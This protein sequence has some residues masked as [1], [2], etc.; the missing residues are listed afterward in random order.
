MNTSANEIAWLADATVHDLIQRFPLPIAL[1]DDAGG[2]L[3][4]NER[5]GRTY[6]TEALASAPLQDLMRNPV[7][8]WHTVRVPDLGQVE[9]EIKAQVLRVQGN[10]MLILDDATDPGLLREL[11]QLH[12]QITELERLSSTDRLTGAWNRAHLD[13]VVAAELDRSLRSRQPVSLILVDID[14]FKLVN[15]TYGHQTGDSVLCELV[16]VIGGAIRSV[17]TLF[18]WGGEEFVVLASSSGYR[19]GTTVAE[20]LRARVA[21]HDFAGVGKVTISLGVAEHIATESAEIWFQRVDRALYRAKDG[22]RNRVCV[23]EQGSSDIWAAESGSS[24][25]RLVW[26]EAYECGEPAIDREHRELFELANALLDASF[27]SESA[28]EVFGAAL[29]KLLA[30]VVQHFAHEEAVLA[31]HN[32]DQLEPHRRA[33]AGLLTRAGELKAAVEGGK[34]TLGDLVDFLATTVVAQHLFKADKE[35]FP[36]FKK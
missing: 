1:L 28:P 4:L 2:A 15:D 22:G 13:R 23:D 5:F 21:R 35:Y 29:Q 25:I 26:Q 11:D 3:V 6:G 12:G 33:H 20:K 34:T 36:L 9:T 8:G 14:H 31:Q 10:P 27:Q 24:V 19:A 18:R 17:D 7:P 32:Y 30:H 16:K